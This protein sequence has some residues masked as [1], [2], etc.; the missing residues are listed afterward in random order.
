M[1]YP[2]CVQCGYC[3]LKTPCGYGKSDSEYE[4]CIFLVQEDTELKTYKCSKYDEIVEK[5][6]GSSYPMFD[7]YCS[8]S[9]HNTVRQAV[10]EKMAKKN[11]EAFADSIKG[12]ENE[13]E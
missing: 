13:N 5:E 2:P 11:S 4:G 12:K 3:C 7:N 6:K 10:V 1:N 8:S 9:L